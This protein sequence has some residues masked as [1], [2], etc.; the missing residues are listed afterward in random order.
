VSSMAKRARVALIGAGWW[1]TEAHM[2]ALLAHE[3]AEIAAICDTDPARLQTAARAFGVER[4]Y[5]A[6][7][8]M[9]AQEELDGVIV[10]TPHA[11]HYEIARA[12][13]EHDLHV[14]L[15]KPMTL[16]A[17]DAKALVDLAASRTRPD[18]RG[19]ELVIGYTYNYLPHSRRA[20][21]V[22]QS[23]ELGEVQYVTCS[24]S[25]DVMGF[26]GG[27]VGDAYSPTRYTI[28]GPS[29]A[30][31]NP[32]L[33]GGG[34]GHLQITHSAGLL[35]FI[36]GLRAQQVHALMRN[37]GLTVDLVD[38]ITVA[39]EGGAVG[40]VGGTGNAGLNYRMA[41]S[42]YCEDGCFLADTLA[43]VA[44]IRRKDGSTEDLTALPRPPMRRGA[45]DN[46]VDVILGRAENGSSGEIGWRTVE[47]LDA[48][49]RSA[50]QNGAGV[51]ISDL[52]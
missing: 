46:F 17:A 22:I 19:L 39:F 20:R 27:Q 52:Y 34:Q 50:A 51:P 32:E 43:A 38:A 26:L 49:Y 30:Y 35:F 9:L 24:F 31:N 10:V 25:S 16:H 28:Q 12:C 13:L 5:S 2:P 33:L 42:V 36:T 14:L 23:G 6:Y 1:A 18:G 4:T 47:L 15:E 41:L 45:T 7:E 44:L 21:E 3:D 37:H 8:A 11:T 29:A 48:A 40:M